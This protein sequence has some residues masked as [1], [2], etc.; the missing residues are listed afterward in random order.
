MYDYEGQRMDDE[1]MVFDD[2]PWLFRFSEH[3]YFDGGWGNKEGF[4]SNAFFTGYGCI[5]LNVTGTYANSKEIGIQWLKDNQSLDGSWLSE[6]PWAWGIVSDFGKY[7]VEDTSMAIIALLMNDS[8]ADVS[9]AVQWLEDQQLSGTAFG[10][11][12]TGSYLF[13]SLNW[14][15]VYSLA[16]GTSYAVRALIK[17]GKTFNNSISAR[18]G[19]R[20]LCENQKSN[21]SWGGIHD[22]GSRFSPYMVAAQAA[23]ALAMADSEF[24]FGENLYPGWNLISV[25]LLQNNTSIETVLASIDGKYDAVEWYNIT[26]TID[27]WKHYKVGKP[28]GNDLSKINETMGFWIHITQPGN[29][30]FIHNGTQPTENQTIAL[31]KGWNLVGYPSLTKRVRTAALNNVDFGSDV[32][33][34]WTYDASSGQWMELELSDS[35]ESGRGYWI[36]SLKETTWEVPI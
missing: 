17:S 35:F 25:P 21:G 7:H 20:W 8:T 3:V 19:I 9:T 1:F 32:D 36:H 29:T 10:Q 14:R 4:E 2:P 18:D 12:L 6:K 28:F 5:G 33:A 22:S 31:H 15:D 24:T 11:D 26:D 16:K 30:I 27:P 34:I 13:S 23:I